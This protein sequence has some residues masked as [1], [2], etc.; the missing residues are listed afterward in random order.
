MNP[1]LP[2]DAVFGLPRSAEI[3]EE[4]Y[5]FFQ[6][7]WFIGHAGARQ[8]KAVLAEDRRLVQVADRHSR[9]DDEFEDVARALETGDA[10]LLPER[11]S[12]EVPLDLAAEMDDQFPA[13]DG[14]ELGVAGLCF[15]LSAVGALTAASCRG[16]RHGWADH[17]VVYFSAPELRARVLERLVGVH[18]CG[19]TT[20]PN[21]GGLLVIEAQSVADF[22][23]LAEAV[24]D[25]RREFAEARIP[26]R[27][28]P[29]PGG[30]G[31]LDL[32]L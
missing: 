8:A 1:K 4:G 19:F 28:R 3:T 10:A 31:E 22:I 29:Q 7:V 20:D 5:G 2:E 6:G 11:L 30:Q 26:R 23:A 13:L 9:D 16:H 17:P 25:A 14:L 32:G 21:R 12:S 15:A 18:R 27:R 24:I